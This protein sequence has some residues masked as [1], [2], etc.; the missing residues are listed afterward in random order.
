MF[1]CLVSSMENSGL[2]MD[3]LNFCTLN[4]THT[5]LVGGKRKSAKLLDGGC[6]ARDESYA[7]IILALNQK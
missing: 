3:F 1:C 6:M 2:S 4:L 7:V 5:Q